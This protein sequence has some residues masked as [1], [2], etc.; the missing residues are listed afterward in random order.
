M[1]QTKKVKVVFPDNRVL[2]NTREEIFK[3]KSR[4]K[5]IAKEK[6]NTNNE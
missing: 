1:N 2:G 6:D 5:R 3:E 4:L